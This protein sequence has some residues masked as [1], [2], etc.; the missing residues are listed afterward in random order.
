VRLRAHL[1]DLVQ[2]P[3]ADFPHPALGQL[4]AEAASAQRMLS[5]R[6]RWRQYAL[7]APINMISGEARDGVMC[8][9]SVEFPFEGAPGAV[10][11]GLRPEHLSFTGSGLSGRVAQLEPMGREI[12]YV[13]DTDAGYL[14]VLERG[15]VAAHVVGEPV[16]IGFSAD[17]SL[18]FDAASQTLVAAARVGPPP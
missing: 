15:S 8:A 9:G 11:V 18:V 17:D 7:D 3:P 10:T 1:R 2:I 12:L 13:V 14:R 4:R 5:N 16:R 6:V